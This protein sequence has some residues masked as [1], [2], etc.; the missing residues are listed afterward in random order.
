MFEYGATARGDY[1]EDPVALVVCGAIEAYEP[2]YNKAPPKEQD[3]LK[4]VEMLKFL[5]EHD[6]N[7]NAL[8]LERGI[9]VLVALNALIDKPENPI[10]K[11]ICKL[12]IKHEADTSKH[13]NDKHKKYIAII[14]K[15]KA[16]IIQETSINNVNV[17]EANIETKTGSRLGET[18]KSKFFL[19]DEINTLSESQTPLGGDIK[20][21]FNSE[22]E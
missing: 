8:I 1:S 19:L 6:G 13:N 21:I 7:P 11:D 10:Y 18:V 17:S 15:L 2:N 20:N 12:L 9:V 22:L 3:L 4:Y 16:E 5:L 14:E